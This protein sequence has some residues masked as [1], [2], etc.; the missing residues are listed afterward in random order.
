MPSFEEPRMRILLV[1]G[2]PDAALV[3]Q[4]KFTHRM[5]H[6]IQVQGSYTWA[7]SVDD[8]NDSLVPAAGNRGFPRN[9]LALSE[10]RG[11]SDNDIRHVAVINYIW[12]VPLG[13]GKGHLSNGMVGKIFEGMQFSGITTAETGHPFDVFSTTDMERTGLSGRADLVGNPFGAPGGNQTPGLKTWF[14]NTALVD[15][16]NPIQFGAFSLRSTVTNVGTSSNPVFVATG[17]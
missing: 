15:P 5:T 3:L 8:S 9:S 2:Q 13:R 12:E 4:A 7:H 6:G 10:E 1:E 16:N 14:N 17:A 11:N